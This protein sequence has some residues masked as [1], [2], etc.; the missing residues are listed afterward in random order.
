MV[1][2]VD[3]WKDGCPLC[4]QR[5]DIHNGGEKMH[6]SWHIRREHDSMPTLHV[7]VESKPL[8]IGLTGELPVRFCPLCGKEL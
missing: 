3:K 4:E 5:A 1:K 6:D 7:V 8:G 2:L